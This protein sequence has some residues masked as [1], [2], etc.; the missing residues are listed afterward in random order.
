LTPSIPD[1]TFQTLG[2][3]KPGE[4]LSLLLYGPSGSGKTYFAGTC[5]P[6]T[7]F[8]NTGDGLETLLSPQFRLRYP[9]SSGMVCVDI[10]EDRGN[11][12]K[13]TTAKGMDLVTD[14]ID[15]YLGNRFH[16]FDTVVLDDATALADFAMLKGL[17]VSGAIGRSK[18]AQ[19]VADK[20][21]VIVP[22]MQDFGMQMALTEQFFKMYT[23]ILKENKK[24][25]VVTA[26]QMM[27]LKSTGKEEVIGGIFPAFT[28]QKRPDTIPKLFDEVWRMEVKNGSIYRAQTVGDGI[29]LAKTRHGGIIEESEKDPNFLSI[30]NRIR[31]QTQS[32]NA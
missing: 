23:S 30:L 9:A 14:T 28:G 16:D 2:E 20:Y 6:R 29:V 1:V 10:R 11:R 8:I 24:S 27:S 13:V 25:F 3:K 21:G 7:L 15:W 4:T 22:A 12:G 19:A 5:G 18:T 31:T 32:K 26:H 17:E